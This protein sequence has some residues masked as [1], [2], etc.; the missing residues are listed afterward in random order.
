MKLKTAEEWAD[1]IE[2]RYMQRPMPK[3][4]AW[5]V[6]A[7]RKEWNEA[8]IKAILE[9]ISADISDLKQAVSFIEKGDRR[10]TPTGRFSDRVRNLEDMIFIALADGRMPETEKELILPFAQEIKIS[11]TQLKEIVSEAKRR[12][13]GLK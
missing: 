3:T 4:F 6:R 7:I 11:Q 12:V 9:D 10:I 1:E 5:Y 13:E 8:V 2:Y